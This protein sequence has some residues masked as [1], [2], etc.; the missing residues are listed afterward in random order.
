MTLAIP[1]SIDRRLEREELLVM[2]LAPAD[3][4][5]RLVETALGN[6]VTDH[7]LG[8]GQDSVGRDRA[9]AAPRT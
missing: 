6:A 7:V 4:N 8:R 9:P 1:A 2:Q 5:R 3:V